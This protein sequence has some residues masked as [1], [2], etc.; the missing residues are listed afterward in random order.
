MDDQTSNRLTM[1]GTCI[2]LAES[3][4]HRPVW[5][6]QEPAA[7]GEELAELKTNYDATKALA[8]QA[9]AATTGAADEKDQ[10]E[11][12][13]E[14][15]AFKLARALALHLKRTGD[16]TR[17]ASVAIPLSKLQGMRDADLIAKAKEILSIAD[18]TKDE[19]KAVSRGVTPARIAA[20]T[21]AHDNFDQLVNAPRKKIVNRTTLLREVEKSVGSLMEDIADIDDLVVQFDGSD[22]GRRFIAAWDRAR[23]IVDAGHGPK[24]GDE[25]PPQS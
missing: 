3:T 7:F 11:T 17:R 8:A 14:D 19:E 1:I 23:I 16:L 5:D 21:A 22:A 24:S 15:A 20:L 18:S 12:A 6:G 4:E 9:D 25:T 10:A 13:L 2:T